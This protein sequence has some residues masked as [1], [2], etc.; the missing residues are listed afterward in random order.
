MQLLN[1]KMRS[2]QWITWQVA[3]SLVQNCQPPFLSLMIY[4]NYYFFFL[5][6]IEDLCLFSQLRIKQSFIAVGIGVVML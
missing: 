5:S 6:F 1:N 3:K 4:Q 2:A